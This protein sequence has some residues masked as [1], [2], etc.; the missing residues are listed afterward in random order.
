MAKVLKRVASSAG[1]P[2]SSDFWRTPSDCFHALDREFN[3]G[4]DLAADAQNHLCT[5]WFGPGSPNEDALTT[6][7]WECGFFA[8]TTD[9]AFLNMPYSQCERWLARVV[10]QIQQCPGC[11]I[12]CLLPYTPDTK[13]WRHTQ[14]AVEIREIPHRVRYLK[15]DGTTPAGAMFPSAVVIFREQPGIVQPQPRRVTWTWRTP[16][17]GSGPLVSRLRTAGELYQWLRPLLNEAADHIDHVK[18]GG[19]AA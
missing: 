19:T 14:H 15:S 10:E 17:N 3:F 8:H 4:L 16:E 6:D 2:K 11:V 13:W 7:W 1:Q 5:Q 9:A 18:K 12:V